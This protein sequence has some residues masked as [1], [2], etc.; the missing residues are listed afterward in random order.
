MSWIE[1]NNSGFCHLCVLQKSNLVL[2]IQN[3]NTDSKDTFVAFEPM[4][5]HCYTWGCRTHGRRRL[6]Q[7]FG[8]YSEKYI[9]RLAYPCQYMDTGKVYQAKL[10]CIIATIRGTPCS[11]TL[12]TS[13][14]KMIRQR[15]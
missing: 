12:K 1:L 14:L 9:L 8:L 6:D 5:L 11:G 10:Q 15:W 7:T 3:N 4:W 2:M 13:P